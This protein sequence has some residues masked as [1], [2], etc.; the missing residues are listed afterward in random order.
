MKQASTKELPV[1]GDEQVTFTLAGVMRGVRRALPVA[2]S[3]FTVGL[4]FGVLG[5]QAGL[6]GVE[7]TL[8]SALVFA[9]ASQFVALSLWLIMPFPVIT[10]IL[11]TLVVN[12]RHLLM[13]ASLRP[14]FA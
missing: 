1:A 14:W 4:V 6:S 10:I 11:T 12:L 2:V 9:G 3:V 13:G 7:A 8:M 5:R